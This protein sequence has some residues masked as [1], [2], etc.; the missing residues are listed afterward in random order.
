MPS[1]TESVFVPAVVALTI[2]SI[3][4]ILKNAGIAVM[5]SDEITVVPALIFVAGSFALVSI[6]LAAVDPIIAFPLTVRFVPSHF[7]FFVA[8]PIFTL[9]ASVSYPRKI[10]ASVSAKLV[11]SVV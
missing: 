9:Y 2:S 1:V 6:L 11:F 8:L 5:L 10:P 4:V 3:V 7:K